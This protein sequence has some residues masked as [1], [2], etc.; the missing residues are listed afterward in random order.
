MND[1]DL[2]LELYEKYRNCECCKG[3]VFNCNG[4]VCEQLGRCY[5]YQRDQAEHNS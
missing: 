3:I 5:C 4:V 1:P 2:L